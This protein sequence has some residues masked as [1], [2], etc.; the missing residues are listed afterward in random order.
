MKGREKTDWLG[1]SGSMQEDPGKYHYWVAQHVLEEE[2]DQPG[3]PKTSRWFPENPSTFLWLSPPS[4]KDN[5]PPI[6]VLVIMQSLDSNVLITEGKITLEVVGVSP[7]VILLH[8]VFSFHS[9]VNATACTVVFMCL[10]DLS[11]SWLCYHFQM[12]IW[13]YKEH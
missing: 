11:R 10:G 13:N 3:I 12:G 9:L 6:F 2:D 1:T 5:K 7:S 4:L 8:D